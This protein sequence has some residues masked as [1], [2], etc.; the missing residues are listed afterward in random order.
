MYKLR[1]RVIV[2]KGD[3][4]VEGEIRGVTHTSPCMYDVLTSKGLIKD[5]L[6]IQLT[7]GVAND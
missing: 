4:N 2:I 1:E 5:V 6:E 3:G 7:K